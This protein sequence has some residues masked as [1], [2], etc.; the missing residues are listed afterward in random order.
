MKLVT[1]RLKVATKTTTYS[2]TVYDDVILVSDAGGSWTLTL[3]PA[4]Y[5]INKT[6]RVKKTNNSSNQVTIDGNGAETIDGALTEALSRQ[7][8]WVDLYSDGTNVHII[9]RGGPLG[10]Q[11]TASSGSFTTTNTAM[12]DVTNLSLTVNTTGRSVLLLL[13][14][15]A[16]AVDTN[17]YGLYMSNAGFSTEYNFLRDATIVR[18]GRTQNNADAAVPFLGVV[19]TPAAGSYVYK[20]QIRAGTVAKTAGCENLCMAAIPL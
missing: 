5:W 6:I 2:A 1:K 4:A 12:T 14:P 16:T 19:D 10:Q 9:G 17:T 3:P 15:A 7:Y 18:F 20:F 13:F 11:V 8:Q